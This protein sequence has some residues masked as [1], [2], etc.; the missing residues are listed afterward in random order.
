MLMA[1]AMPKPLSGLAE[2]HLAI[3]LVSMQPVC[4][5]WAMRL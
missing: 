4:F 1:A 5:L 2:R 3:S